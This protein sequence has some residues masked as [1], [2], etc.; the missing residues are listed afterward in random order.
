MEDGLES[1][2]SLEAVW[3]QSGSN[4]EEVWKQCG[5]ILEAVWKQSGSSLEAFWK[6]SGSSLEAVSYLGSNSNSS[7]PECSHAHV[8][9]IL[10]SPVTQIL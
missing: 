8:H 4:L 5:D 9:G 3:K 7:T 1:G 2:S 10:A 6:K